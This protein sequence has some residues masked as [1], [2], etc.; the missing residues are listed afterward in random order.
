MKDLSWKNQFIARLPKP[1]PYRDDLPFQ[2]RPANMSDAVGVTTQ[3]RRATQIS[4]YL[5]MYTS[6]THEPPNAEMYASGSPRPHRCSVEMEHDKASESQPA[7][8][9]TSC[10]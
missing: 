2:P 1:A 10:K 3:P 8:V 5:L 7:S 4:R 9:R 6:I